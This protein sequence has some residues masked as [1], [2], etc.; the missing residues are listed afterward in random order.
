M[1]Q[2]KKQYKFFFHYVLDFI[3]FIY[4][5]LHN[6][7]K[8]VGKNFSRV[9]QPIE[10]LIGIIILIISIIFLFILFQKSKFY[11]IIG[12]AYEITSVFN[13]VNSITIGTDV[14]LNGVKVGIIEDIELQDNYDV[15]IDLLINDS[16]EIPIDSIATISS[17]NIIGSASITILSGVSQQIMV[18]NDE[19]ETKST[20]SLETLIRKTL[21]ST[22]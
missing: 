14:L 20:E 17:M 2:N 12:G 22:E 9:E 21:F 15:R 19:I 5:S 16:I 4:R 10:A 3:L 6:F 18:E 11:S 1:N 8:Y 7:L 13:N